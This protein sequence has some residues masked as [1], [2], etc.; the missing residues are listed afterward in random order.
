MKKEIIKKIKI[1]EGVKCEYEN[2]IFKCG[3]DSIELSKKLFFP[4]IKIEIKDSEIEINCKKGNRIHLKIINTFIAH[5]KNLFAGLDKP[6]VY[7]LE[8]CNVHFPISLKV[9]G[10]NLI[11]NNFF[12]EKVPRKAK[13]LEGV[14]VKVEKNKITVSSRYKELA[15]QTAA[16]FEK[17]TKI[18]ERD[19]R[20]FQDGIYITKKPGDRR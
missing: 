2:H 3:K 6:F 13:I 16:N 20:I 15:G 12:G 17:A 14:D 5:I 11:I 1:P 9:D 8:T 7:E 19:P 4:G 10:S 18:K